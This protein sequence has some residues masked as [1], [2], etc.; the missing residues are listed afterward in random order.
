MET[1]E[2]PMNCPGYCC[3]SEAMGLETLVVSK[4]SFR[5]FSRGRNEERKF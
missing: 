1:D 5:G 3:E 4:L 2:G